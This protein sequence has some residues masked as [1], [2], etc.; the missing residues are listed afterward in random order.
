LA[1][2]LLALAAAAVQAEERYTRSWG[3]YEPPDVTLVDAGGAPVPLRAELDRPGPVL[4]QF[5][6]TTCS[7]VCPVLGATFAA[8]QDGLPADARL[9]SISIDPE[10]DTPARL[11]EHAARL[12]AGSRWRFLTGRGAD[13]IAVEKAF[14]AYAG[15]DKM[16]H[17]PLTFLR[18]APGGRW[19]RLDGFPRPA[20]LGSELRGL[21]E[22]GRRL[23]REGVLPS[24]APLRGELPGGAE[25]AGA[26]AACAGCH[27]RSG[28]G[29]VEGREVVPP[30][31]APA[32][33]LESEPR[34]AELFRKLYQEDLSP[35]ALARVRDLGARP[36][37]TAET[38]ATALREGR[39][40]TGRALDP[41]MPRY[42][43]DDRAMA[44]LTAYLRTLSAAPAPGVDREEIHFATVVAPGAGSAERDA[45]LGVMRAFFRRENG[46]QE[47]LRRRPEYSPLY[48]GDLAAA[49]RDWVLHVWELTG[50]P[51]TWGAQ[52]AARYREQPVFALL[53]GVAGDSDWSPVHAFCESEEI[54]CLFPETG[55]PPAAPGAYSFYLS[56]GLS[57]EAEA[58]ARHLREAAPP[59]RALRVVQ[60]YRGDPAGTVPAAALRRAL[61][62]AEGVQVADRELA[63]GEPIVWDGEPDA[64][65]LWL[66]AA[67]VAKLPPPPGRGRPSP[68]LYLSWSLL[69]ESLPVLPAAWR[70]R[71]L[72]VDRLAPP[73]VASPH[74][75]RARAWL[76]SRGLERADDR[77]ELDTWFTLSLTE[78]ALMHLVGGISRDA[79]VEIVERETERVPNPGVYP[80]LTLG[81]G[82][83]FASRSCALLQP[84]GEGVAPVGERILP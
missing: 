41:L 40:P 38:L 79:F 42:R 36:A 52:L 17:L 16:R 83:R 4:L 22:P 76:R 45:V 46:D 69:G 70:D 26:A 25:V 39:D 34:R 14:D 23:Y 60:F 21:S 5:I 6:F 56:A 65:V 66:P 59:G 81:P 78:S 8:A 61:G 9:L 44:D 82:Q 13:V 43:L 24:G 28:S 51:E 62:G 53:S 48:K 68:R 32:L 73:G 57:L 64:V 49:S 77:L 15:D 2:A 55:L 54:P 72:I 1:A 18:A 33:F 12:R 63:A 74:A 7:T 58:L 27:R 47:R 37:Y 75:Y 29:G 35:G 80:R 71:T 3:D 67:D 19:L 11:A 31:A 30:I 20:D 10:Q 50:A 84:L